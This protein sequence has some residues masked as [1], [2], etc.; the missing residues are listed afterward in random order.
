M[1]TVLQYTLVYCSEKGM[2]KA[3]CI[4]IQTGCAGRGVGRRRRRRAG[5]WARV[6]A[7]RAGAGALHGQ[8]R[9]A[10]TAA[11]AGRGR[12]AWPE[13]AAGPAGC[14]LGALGLFLTRFDS[15]LF[16]SQFLDIV[17]E[18]GS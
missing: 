2:R 10:R 11:G 13:R 6:S 5:R 14:A 16:L 7:G 9:G 4:A 17:R 3:V 15:V 8:A 18:P 1:G 12:G